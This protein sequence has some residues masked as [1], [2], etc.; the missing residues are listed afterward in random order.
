MGRGRL[1]GR[2]EPER[3]RAPELTGISFLNP[4][5][6]SAPA[7]FVE[8]AVEIVDAAGFGLGFANPALVGYPE[9]LRP[10]QAAGVFGS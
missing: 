7:R 2:R 8:A 3:S 10:V 1:D 5:L 4:P 9:R 6:W